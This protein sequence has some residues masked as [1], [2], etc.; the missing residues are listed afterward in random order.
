[1]LK[2]IALF[3]LN[4]LNITIGSSMIVFHPYVFSSNPVSIHSKCLCLCLCLCGNVWQY[5]PSYACEYD[6]VHDCGCACDYEHD[7]WN[8]HDHG[9]E[10]L[11]VYDGVY[12]LQDDHGD[13]YDDHYVDGNSCPQFERS[14]LYLNS[15][16]EYPCL[17]YG[18]VYQ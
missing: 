10:M 15:C 13:G 11:Y 7:H 12:V 18:M 3:S 9:Y 4:K 16:I 8:V 17:F 5:E 14:L 2:F 1:M 6:C